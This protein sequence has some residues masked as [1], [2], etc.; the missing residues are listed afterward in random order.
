L[1]DFTYSLKGKQSFMSAKA[2]SCSFGALP[3]DGDALL[4]VFWQASY[5]KK[6]FGLSWK[7]LQISC[8]FI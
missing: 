2:I 5:Q 8:I 7:I 4:S 6:S 1:I 3:A